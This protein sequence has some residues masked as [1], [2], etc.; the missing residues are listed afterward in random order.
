MTADFTYDLVFGGF[1]NTV[2]GGVW[3]EDHTRHEYRDWHRVTDA[4]IG[5]QFGTTPYWYQYSRQ[6]PQTTFKWYLENTLSADKYSVKIGIKQFNNEVDR[7]DL[8]G[9]TP[10]ASLSADSDLLLSGGVNFTPFEGVEL[11]AG[12]SENYQALGDTILE[13]P[14]T[15][16]GGLE[17]QTAEV[18]E[19]GVRFENGPFAGAVTYF[20][21]Q[22]ENRLF[23]LDATSA[24]GP[25][26]TIGTD[27]SFFNAGGIDQEGVEVLATWQV[28]DFFGLYA[29]YT[30]NDSTY[31]GTDDPLVD[32]QVGIVPGNQVAGIPK[33][34]FVISA[35]FVRDAFY[36]GASNKWV[37]ERSVYANKSWVADGYSVMDLYAGVSGEGI[38][39]SLSG[40]DLRVAVNNVLDEDYLGTIAVK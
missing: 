19:A 3:Y 17:P 6:Y 10:N 22:F 31:L 39:D 26:Y 5:P 33:D 27:G 7:K 4:R 20:N 34:M 18:I 11:F 2:R 14:A 12:Y 8:F 35:D 23:F 21:T 36:A 37:G 9:D 30:Y 38:S 25:N 32:A 13:R 29:S 28:T 40:V 15:S 16:L 1:E 24:T